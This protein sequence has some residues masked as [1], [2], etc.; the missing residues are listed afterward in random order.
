MEA[1]AEPL[2][3][4]SGRQFS[5]AGKKG[6]T[7]K[8]QGTGPLAVAKG[9]E[10][11][12]LVQEPDQT[13]LADAVL[14]A[15]DPAAGIGQD[16]QHLLVATL[17]KAVYYLFGAGLYRPLDEVRARKTRPQNSG[18]GRA[19]GLLH[20]GEAGVDHG[21]DPFFG[22]QGRGQRDAE[23]RHEQF[24]GAGIQG[25]GYPGQLAHGVQGDGL[26]IKLVADLQDIAG[27]LADCRT[28]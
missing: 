23:P 20:H 5:Q 22:P 12:K 3:R 15:C 9:I 27:G 2:P 1:K 7:G 17:D 28:L 13:R 10:A 14:L 24:E 26:L 19:P 25:K 21:F 18:P 4:Q 6:F 8:I 16:K 11:K